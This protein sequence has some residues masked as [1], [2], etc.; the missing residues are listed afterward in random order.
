MKKLICSLLFFA[1]SVFLFVSCSKDFDED[2]SYDSSQVVG[3][4]KKANS[5]EYWRYESSGTGNFWDEDEDVHE[6]EGTHFTWSLSGVE[7]RITLVGQMGQEVPCDY[8]IDELT[9]STMVLK[10]A[11]YDTKT[12][13]YKQ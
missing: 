11:M 3:K 4:W 8:E 2:K 10:D 5:N 12:T 1:A 7:L 6:G 9:S 13:Y